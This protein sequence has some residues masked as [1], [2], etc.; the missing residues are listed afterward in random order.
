MALNAE[1][2]PDYAFYREGVADRQITA[3]SLNAVCQAQPQL[4]IA[5][6]GCLA[7]DPADAHHYLPWLQTQ[8]DEV[9]TTS[10]TVIVIDCVPALAAASV[11]VS[12][13]S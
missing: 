4:E 9:S 3:A 6:T 13:I 12:V 7:L 11:A 5:C 10:V 8:K 2:H 1:G